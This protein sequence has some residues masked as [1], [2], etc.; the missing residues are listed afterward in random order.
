LQAIAPERAAQLRPEVERVRN[1]D[2]DQFNR[3]RATEA[4]N[5]GVETQLAQAF[6]GAEG[7]QQ[8]QLQ[9]QQ[10]VQGIMQSANTIIEGA[11]RT[12]EM[13]AK[14]G[15]PI[16]M[17]TSKELMRRVLMFR[18]L[19]SSAQQAAPGA[20]GPQFVEAAMGEIQGIQAVI[21]QQRGFE[22]RR[23]LQQEGHQAALQ[24]VAVAA[25]LRAASMTQKPLPPAAARA[26]RDFETA[27]ESIG[28]V[29]DL[30]KEN[31]NLGGFIA[32][33]MTSPNV[34]PYASELNDLMAEFANLNTL[35]LPSRLGA[36][37][38]I[39]DRDLLQ[40]ITFY[41]TD[42]PV[43][44]AS[45]LNTVRRV[46]LGN[47]RILQEQYGGT[48]PGELLS[49]GIAAAPQEGDTDLDLEI[50]SGDE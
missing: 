14:S 49:G 48:F 23:F 7:R 16:E 4:Q 22:Q 2:I 5:L 26:K 35:L 20:V 3:E 17:E 37:L 21:D 47:L 31:P 46:I 50:E 9:Q 13:L 33:H 29:T 10:A 45:K 28:K 27:L 38:P 25:A 40:G 44:M 34:N 19:V 41:T 42:N 36:A 6:T 18:E 15:D 24:R 1:L 39:G 8:E 30:L 32:G 43:E 11:G 12:A